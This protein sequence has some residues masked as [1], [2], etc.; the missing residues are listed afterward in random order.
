MRRQKIGASW[1]EGQPFPG[2]LDSECA[3]EMV[4]YDMDMPE[5]VEFLHLLL[6]S[7]EQEYPE[8]WKISKLMT[9]R[10]VSILQRLII[11]NLWISTGLNS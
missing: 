9:K 6:K 7:N 4:I 10:I 1:S 11:G 2:K 3:N 8:N 5:K